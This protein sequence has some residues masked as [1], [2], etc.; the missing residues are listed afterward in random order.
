MDKYNL[1]DRILSVTYT[2][3]AIDANKNNGIYFNSFN[4]NN[5]EHKIFLKIGFIVANFENKK[6][7]L[8][9]KYF[10]F[11]KILFDNYTIKEIFLRKTRLRFRRFKHSPCTN[12]DFLASFE[13]KEFKVNPDIF[14]EIWT[15]YYEDNN[16]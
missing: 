8:N 11:L 5:T 3:I 16:N 6:I 9:T 14:E 12:I 1:Y 4:K 13:I 15:A 7:Y 2:N 10:D